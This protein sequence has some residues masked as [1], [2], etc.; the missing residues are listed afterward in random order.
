MGRNLFIILI[1][2]IFLCI[3]AFITGLSFDRY[4]KRRY[5]RISSAVFAEQNMERLYSFFSK[6]PGFIRLNNE[7]AYKISVFNTLSLEK[8]KRLSAVLFAIYAGVLCLLSVTLLIYFMPYWYIALVY[9]ILSAAAILFAVQILSDGVMHMYLKRMP[10][11]IKIL[12]TRVLSGGSISKA[13]Y[14]SIPD[15]PKGI[16]ADM[17]RIYDA[18]KLNEADKTKTVFREIDRKYGNV[19]MSI[20]LDFIWI[21][22]YNG[23]GDRI[24][25]QF[26][27]MLQDVSEKIEN[28]REL[29]GAAM[30]HII[31][32]IVFI[33]GT[34]V[35]F[36]DMYIGE[37]NGK[38]SVQKIIAVI[39]LSCVSYYIPN[40]VKALH[41]RRIICKKR[42]ELRFLKRIFV[43]SGSSKPVDYMQVINAMYER[44][45]YYK[46]DMGRLMDVLRK[47]SVDKEDFFSE[48]LTETDDTDTK[49]FYEKLSI[50]FLYD[51]DLAVRSIEGDFAQEKRT[52]VR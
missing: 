41:N 9:I 51:F 31:M 20:L 30:R 40:A 13:I 42:S 14:R 8:N 44:A 10:E 7:M 21:S 29:R 38:Q 37:T 24:K 33:I 39:L 27:A 4:R 19:H 49:L 26:E 32:S 45:V 18:L 43:I 11:A 36:P 17:I 50:G 22:H 15:M 12:Q 5:G 46:K 35:L 52:C 1:V 28:Q 47:S 3:S 48:L 25:T 16:K 34:A 6:C 2:G 23:C